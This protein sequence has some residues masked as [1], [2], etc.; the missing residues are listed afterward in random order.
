MIHGFIVSPTG[1]Y[2][3]FVLG[4]GAVDS[5]LGPKRSRG[6][7]LEPIAEPHAIPHPPLSHDKEPRGRN[8]ASIG[9]EY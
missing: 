9:E 1:L 5:E 2:L 8:F 3:V 4:G 6:P 7:I